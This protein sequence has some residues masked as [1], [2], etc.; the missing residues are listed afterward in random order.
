MKIKETFFNLFISFCF[1]ILAALI[2]TICIEI[3][4]DDGLCNIVSKTLVAII[5]GLIYR[6]KIIDCF[7]NFKSD[8]KNNY[9]SILLVSVSLLVIIFIGTEILEHCFK[10]LPA[11][12]LANRKLIRSNALILGLSSSL[13]TPFAEEFMFRLPYHKANTKFAFVVYSI[14][15]ALA[16][17]TFVTSDLIFIPFYLLLSISFGYSYYKTNNILMSIILHIINNSLCVMLILI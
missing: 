7:K 8:L 3:I 9:K 4:K 6:N 1:F 12:E 10:M 5:I 14:V 13:F 17:I 2:T 16:H 15:F 11:N